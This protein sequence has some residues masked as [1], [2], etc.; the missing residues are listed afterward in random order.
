MM[1]GIKETTHT[2]AVKD[3]YLMNVGSLFPVS[4]DW[5]I[6]LIFMKN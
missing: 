3:I 1:A 4:Q 5:R 2:P 6:P